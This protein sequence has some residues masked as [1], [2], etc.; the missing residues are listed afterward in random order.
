[1]NATAIYEKDHIL[2]SA[3]WGVEIFAVLDE[4]GEL[5]GETTIEFYDEKDDYIERTEENKEKLSKAAMWIGFQLRPDLT[6]KGIGS[7]F[8]QA[9]VD[10]AVDKNNYKGEYIRLAVYD[11]NERAKKAYIK[12]GFEPI[13][14]II[15]DSGKS[16]VFMRKKL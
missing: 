5:I 9:S 8:V 14:K 11:F 15:N 10:F 3:L 12:A 6:G 7:R 4:N 2:D 13:K 16:V 1:M